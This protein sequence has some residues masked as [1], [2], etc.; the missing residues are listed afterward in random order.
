[1]LLKSRRQFT[2]LAIGLTLLGSLI[3]LARVAAYVNSKGRNV[4]FWDQWESSVDIALRAVEGQLTVTDLNRQYNEH[5][6]PLSNLVTAILARSTGWNLRLEMYLSVAIACLTL[7]LL[8]S[9]LH[10]DSV[11]AVPIAAVPF[12]ALMFSLAQYFNW[13]VGFQTESYFVNLFS[14]GV[15]WIFRCRPVGW[16]ALFVASMLGVAATF[17]QGAGVVIWPVA[18]LQLCAGGYWRASFVIVWNLVAA[19]TIGLFFWGYSF[20]ARPP[21]AVAEWIRY[22]LTFL[23]NPFVPEVQGADGIARV[24][25]VVGGVLFLANVAALRVMGRPLAAVAHW[26]S[27]AGLSLGAAVLAAP[28]RCSFG[29]TS[30]LTSRYVTHSTL[31]WVALVAVVS[32]VIVDVLRADVR[33]RWVSMVAGCTVGLL[34]VLSV[35]WA[36]VDRRG[37][38]ATVVSDKQAQCLLQYPTSRDA[39]CLRGI[40]PAF[41]PGFTDDQYRDEILRRVDALYAH[42]LA[43]FSP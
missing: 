24:F 29:V 20:P 41:E 27:V 28:L 16:A 10:R 37:H 6:F 17:S 8:L 30:A 43:I 14:I 7:L 9:M 12:S 19:A 23:G 36:K 34:A 21:V 18:L 33:R 4:P 22:T 31:F 15:I 3:P 13:L 35:C 26:V 32:V 25:A 40:H 38:A 11:C 2:A 42:R 1:M 39:V 5:R